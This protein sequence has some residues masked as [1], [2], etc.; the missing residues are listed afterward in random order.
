MKTKVAKPTRKELERQIRELESQLVHRLAFTAKEL[1]KFNR[2]KFTGSGVIVTIEGLG[3]RLKLEPVM[4][5]DGLSHATIDA[6]K[7][8]ILYSFEIATL[9]KP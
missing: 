3:G 1:D 2:E 9:H 4:L 5:R 8:D 7:A 6:L